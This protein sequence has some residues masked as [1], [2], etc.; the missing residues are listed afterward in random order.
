MRTEPAPTASMAMPFASPRPWLQTVVI[1]LTAFLTLVD[2]FAMQA[3]LPALVRHYG[4]S[5]GAMGVAVNASTIGMAFSSLAT[6]YLSPSIDR[7][8]G[9]TTS[10]VLLAIPTAA[11]AYA[12][13]L[14]VFTGLRVLQGVFMAA[15]FTLM[16]AYLGE[17]YS[18]ADGAAAFAAYIA[19][20]VASNFFGRLLSASVADQ[21][22]LAT[23]FFVFAAL[24]LAGAALVH[25]TVRRAPPMA[26]ATAPAGSV[27]GAL[28]LHLADPQ[29]RASFAIGFLILFAFIG[30]FTY[31]NLVLAAPPLALGMMEIGF[32]YFVFAPSV[33][34]TLLA[35][36]LAPRLGA[37]WSLLLSLGTA[38][39]GLPL[40]LLPSLA[41]VLAGLVLF[42]VGTFAA[43]AVATGH[44]GRTAQRERGA[45]SG[46]YLASY[47]FGGLVGSIALGQ[48]F[49]RF[50]WGATVL[51]IGLALLAAAGL[52]GT[53][54]ERAGKPRR[55]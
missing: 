18:A 25:A 5:P 23:T 19:G 1:A 50:G 33:A 24:N 34:T 38:L 55:K 47:F 9:I 7:R 2:L 14:A 39:A 48:V 31:V 43:Q 21:F 27:A 37:R 44:V 40:L 8:R 53:L 45:A 49:Q 36:G 10:L 32:V 35:G 26:A 52:A 42:A 46:L 13:D 54:S 17:H 20:N 12:P 41:A 6:S 15:A 51:V 22:G 11:L 28:R 4:A 30:L 29:L 3:I 16:L